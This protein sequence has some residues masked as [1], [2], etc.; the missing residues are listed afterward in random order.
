ME[1]GDPAPHSGRSRGADDTGGPD[2]DRAALT[3][4]TPES[5]GTATETSRMVH[6]EGGSFLMG[7]FS[8]P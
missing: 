5:V 7:D 1:C 4:D 6:F 3:V 8:R 2:L